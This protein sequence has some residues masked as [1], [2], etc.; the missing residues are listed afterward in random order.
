MYVIYMKLRNTFAPPSRLSRKLDLR[1]SDR[2]TS[3][4]IT[5]MQTTNDI[6]R[7]DI[8]STHINALINLDE[9]SDTDIG[10]AR[11]NHLSLTVKRY[12]QQF[13]KLVLALI[14]ATLFRNVTMTACSVL[15]PYRNGRIEMLKIFHSRRTRK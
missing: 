8:T 10:N 9:I 6:R 11:W 7:P 1:F 3:A 2:R 15:W 5:E 13:I 14:E 12:G 4:D